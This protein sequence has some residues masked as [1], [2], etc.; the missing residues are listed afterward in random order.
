MAWIRLEP[1]KE[2]MKGKQQFDG[3]CENATD[4]SSEASNGYAEYNGS[5]TVLGAGS[6]VYCLGDGKL[7]VKKEDLSWAE[8]TV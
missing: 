2:V 5:H 7:Y 8:V 3:I 6:A 4:L 1:Q